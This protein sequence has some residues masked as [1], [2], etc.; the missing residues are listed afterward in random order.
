MA[1]SDPTDTA[2][3]PLV[4]AATDDSPEPPAFD[5]RQFDAPQYD[6]IA[7]HDDLIQYSKAYMAVVVAHYD[8][9]VDAS[10]IYE[11]EVS[12]RAD[13]TAA[14]VKTAD[15]KNLGV[16]VVSGLTNPDWD[17]L[18]AE[19][20]EEV[21]K[22]LGVSDIKDVRVRLTWG[23]FEAFDEEQWRATLRHEAVHIEQYHRYG[24]GGHGAAFAIRA[25]EVD[26][27]EDCPKFSDF[28]YEFYCTECGADAG[29]R[30]QESK[31]VKSARAEDGE[32]E[33]TCCGAPLGLTD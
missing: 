16:F 7:S 24:K 19:Y 30:Y 10:H 33:S 31:V 28:N 2:D 20:N 32:Y 12:T 13:R 9:N 18:R 4:E 8:L 6:E 23:A 22:K 11:W 14:V 17:A 26:V 1:H 3:D 29:G 5:P 15:L 25:D 27:S 21:Q